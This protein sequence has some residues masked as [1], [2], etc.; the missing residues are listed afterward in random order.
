MNWK[1]D[2]ISSFSH[3]ETFNIYIMYIRAVMKRIHKGV[4]TGRICTYCFMNKQYVKRV[5]KWRLTDSKIFIAMLTLLFNGWQGN[6][7]T[8]QRTEAKEIEYELLGS[9]YD[10]TWDAQWTY[11][12]SKEGNYLL[13]PYNLIH[14]YSKIMSIMWNS[15]NLVEDLDLGH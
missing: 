4:P 11:P 12:L 15:N 3:T 8:V 13:S 9:S 7:S 5:Q 6:M 2:K 14:T 10:T 1:R